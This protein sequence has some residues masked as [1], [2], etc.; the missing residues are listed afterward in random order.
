MLRI[1]RSKKASSRRGTTAL[2]Q[3]GQAVKARAQAIS[4]LPQLQTCDADIDIIEGIYDSN[5]ANRFLVNDGSGVFTED[6]NSLFASLGV[7]T[8]LLSAADL[9]GDGGGCMAQH[10]PAMLVQHMHT[11]PRF[12]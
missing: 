11:C 2:P 5:Q 3:T 1:S 10:M 12:P 7:S 8:F 6:T 4:P 9:G